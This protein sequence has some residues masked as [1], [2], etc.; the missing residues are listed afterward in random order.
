MFEGGNWLFFNNLPHLVE[1]FVLCELLFCDCWHT[2]RQAEETFRLLNFS[3][4]AE[5]MEKLQELFIIRMSLFLVLSF[6]FLW[7]CW[8]WWESAHYVLCIFTDLAVD[9]K[10]KPWRTEGGKCEEAIVKAPRSIVGST[11][12]AGSHAIFKAIESFLGKWKGLDFCCW[13]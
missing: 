5:Q 3:N 13:S 8:A 11:G 10:E 6:F 7:G 12:M 1:G 9:G 2:N 4:Q